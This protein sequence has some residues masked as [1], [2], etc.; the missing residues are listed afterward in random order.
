[1]A[2]AKRNNA[3]MFFMRYLQPRLTNPNKKMFIVFPYQYAQEVDP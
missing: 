3:L 1:M 2:N